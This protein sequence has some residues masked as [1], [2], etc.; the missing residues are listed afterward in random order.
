MVPPESRIPFTARFQSGG[1]ECCSH[2]SIQRDLV[3]GRESHRAMQN[4][5]IE[6]YIGRPTFRLPC[7]SLANGQSSNGNAPAPD[8]KVDGR[9]AQRK[10]SASG[11]L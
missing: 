10:K 8:G 6:M 3:K 2:T 5:E 1:V 11:T 7:P 9:G 4:R